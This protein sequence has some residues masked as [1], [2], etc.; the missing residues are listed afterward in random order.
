MQTHETKTPTRKKEKRDTIQRRGAAVARWRGRAPL[1]ARP[2]PAARASPARPEGS[3]DTCR[4]RRR[5]RPGAAAPHA[6]PRALS[7]SPRSPAEP[8]VAGPPH[9]PG[10]R[11]QAASAAPRSA[12]HVTDRGLGASSS[13]RGSSEWGARAGRFS[14]GS[15]LR[16]RTAR[17]CGPRR[18]PAGCDE[19]RRPPAG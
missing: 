8:R 10:T 11:A 14:R 15:Q 6:L 16:R 17:A 3:P 9:L 1:V 13:L 19:V 12:R 5:P 18:P 2:G 7:A 4:L